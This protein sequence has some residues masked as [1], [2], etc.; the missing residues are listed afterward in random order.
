MYIYSS[1]VQSFFTSEI[2]SNIEC[3][4]IGV[5]EILIKIQQFYTRK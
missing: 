1:L 3:V 5:I 4:G 2:A